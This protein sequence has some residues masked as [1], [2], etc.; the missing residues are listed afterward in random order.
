MLPLVPS[1][2]LCVALPPSTMLRR[3]A[4]ADGHHCQGSIEHPTTTVSFVR[5]T[6]TYA[7]RWLIG[8]CLLESYPL[9]SAAVPPPA[10]GHHH[11]GLSPTPRSPPQTQANLWKPIHPFFSLT[12]APHH[13]R[14]LLQRARALP[15]LSGVGASSPSVAVH[16]LSLFLSLMGGTWR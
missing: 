13:R 1:L 7:S 5:S 10:S 15:P 12:M 2:S 14:N 3:A 11:H 8:L 16:S 6:R 9:H 4:M